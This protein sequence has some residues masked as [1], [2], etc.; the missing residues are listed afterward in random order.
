MMFRRL[1]VVVA[2]IS[3][4]LAA[5]SAPPLAPTAAPVATPGAAGDVRYS[6]ITPAQL[7]ELLKSKDF[8][9]VNVHIPYAGEITATDAFIP[10]DQ[11]AQLL[12]QYPASRQAKIVVYCRNGHMSAI[13]AA[14]LVKAGYTNVWNLEGGMSAW[15]QAGYPLL[16]K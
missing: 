13:A 12:G 14:E 5:C 7:A 2:L 10:Y 3:G 4:L 6:N 1:V 11:T 16:Q 8:F 15:E 9:L